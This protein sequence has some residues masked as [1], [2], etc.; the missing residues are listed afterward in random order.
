MSFEIDIGYASLSGRRERNEDFV[1]ALIAEPHELNERGIILAVADGVSSGGGGLEAAQTTVMTL[2][3]GYFCTPKTWES[4]VALDRI[5][6]CQNGWLNAMNHRD[7]QCER[8]TTLTALVLRGQTYTIA[9]IGDTRAYMLRDQH[10]ERLT[11]DHTRSGDMKSVLTRALGTDERAMVD[12]VQGDLRLGDTLLLMSDGAWSKLKDSD[13]ISA[14]GQLHNS[15]Q[16]LADQLTDK[17][18]ERGSTDNISVVAATVRG[19]PTADLRAG[20]LRFKDL[21]VPKKLRIGESIDGFTVTQ[22]VANNGINMVYQVRSFDGEAG[23]LK[24]LK[25]LAPERANDL[26]ER[27]TLAHEQWLAEQLDDAAFVK[28]YSVPNASALYVLYEWHAGTTLE[29]LIE[30]SQGPLSVEDALYLARQLL[31]AIA[32]LH[33]RGII[34]RD[35]KPANLHKD[36]KGQWRIFDLGVAVSGEEPRSTRELH[37]GTPSFINPEQWEGETANPQSDLFAAGVT[38]YQALTKHLPYGEIQPYQSGRYHRDATAPTRY[39]SDLPMWVEAIL[40]KAVA[41]NPKERFETA[42]EFILAIERGA[43]RPLS[44]PRATPLIE[45]NLIFALKLALGFS[46]LLNMLLIILVLLTGK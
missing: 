35:I 14:A 45:R 46:L 43:A 4:T 33:R 2:L 39:R 28:T 37:A 41:R 5:I 19:L 10:L 42:E 8:A 12:Y 7:T 17:A 9:H 31:A 34:H 30:P 38:L 44:A 25:T 26:E 24:A 27:A 32:K 23:A 40:L 15:A 11:I 36:D 20:T 13:I 16:V 29:K 6:S 3:D 22:V 18:F 21:P 1:G